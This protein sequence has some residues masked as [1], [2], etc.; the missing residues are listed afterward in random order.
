MLEAKSAQFLAAY[1]S[2]FLLLDLIKDEELKLEQQNQILEIA[3]AFDQAA[4]IIEASFIEAL[5]S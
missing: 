3:E 1:E 4:E 2:K 5:T